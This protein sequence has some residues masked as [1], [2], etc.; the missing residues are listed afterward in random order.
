MVREAETKIYRV[1]HHHTVYLKKGLVEDSAFPF[2]VGQALIVK[3]EGDRLVI[4]KA[5]R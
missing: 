2:K 4:E 3:V 5:K 1:G